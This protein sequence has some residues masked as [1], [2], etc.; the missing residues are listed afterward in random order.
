MSIDDTSSHPISV[1]SG[2]PQ[3]SVLGLLLFLVYINVLPPLISSSVRLFADDC[4]IYRRTSHPSDSEILQRSIDILAELCL[5]WKMNINIAKINI[6]SFNRPTTYITSYSYNSVAISPI[7]SYKY[8]GITFTDDLSWNSLI[9]NIINKSSKTLAFLWRHFFQARQDV[10]LMPYKTLVLSKLEYASTIWDPHKSYLVNRLVSI[11]SRAARFIHRNY[12]F[13]SS[14]SQLKDLSNL[15]SLDVLRKLSGL[16]FFH[17]IYTSRPSFMLMYG[18]PSS[19]ISLRYDHSLKAEPI[20]GR[21]N[22][23]RFSTLVLSLTNWNSLTDDS[24][25]EQDPSVFRKKCL[26]LLT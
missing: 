19:Y 2:V 26:I 10:K 11:Q 22:R 5:T 9:D 16:S 1:K 25:K 7:P 24:V 21:T 4:V 12:S 15:T 3:G 17:K 14:V 23:F 8:L 13:N 18:K 20:F 6:V